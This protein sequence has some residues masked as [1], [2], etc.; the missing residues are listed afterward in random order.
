MEIDGIIKTNTEQWF[1]NGELSEQYDLI[2][3]AVN[4]MP[5]FS[6]DEVAKGTLMFTDFGRRLV[7]AILP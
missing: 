5:E 6:K 7:T 4:K 1:D 2:R 3:L